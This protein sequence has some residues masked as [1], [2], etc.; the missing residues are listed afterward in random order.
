M[1]KVVIYKRQVAVKEEDKKFGGADWHKCSPPM[2]QDQAEKL[3]DLWKSKN[4]LID[5]KIEKV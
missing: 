4:K 2:L 3:I 5:Y 1:D